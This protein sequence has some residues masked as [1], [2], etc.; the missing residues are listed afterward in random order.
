MPQAATLPA[1][2]DDQDQLDQSFQERFDKALDAA[3]PDESPDERID[4]N[5]KPKGKG[6]S[7]AAKAAPASKAPAAPPPKQ[8]RAPRA[9]APAAPQE[10]PLSDA[11]D[12]VPP[13]EPVTEPVLD[14]TEDGDV[15][16][17]AEFF[18]LTPEDLQAEYGSK[19]DFI[20]AVRLWDRRL[21]SAGGQAHEQLPPQRQPTPPPQQRPAPS[22][23]QSEQ[24]QAEADA[25]EELLKAEFLD[26]DATKKGFGAVKQRLQ[27]QEQVI[28]QLTQMLV[29]QR[30]QELS[31]KFDSLVDD[32]EIEDLGKVD[33]RGKLKQEF[34]D[35]RTEVWQLVHQMRMHAAQQ[36]GRMPPLTKSI[37]ERA[38]HIAF[39]KIQ[40]QKLRESLE[41]QS[42]RRLGTAVSSRG[43]LPAPSDRDAQDAEDLRVI[44]EKWRAMQRENGNL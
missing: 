32:L 4:P 29:G 41:S 28:S 40:T 12:Q 44:T 9:D 27:Q 42:R 8:E 21:A 33:Q 26:D 13:E 24:T 2:G 14:W 10:Q 7:K 23:P 34:A 1:T 31:D 5:G 22:Q 35:K 18:G 25:L 39:P 43:N 30:Q 3:L 16:D 38:V 6:S 36:T 11:E 20:R 15:L 17:A 37:V 19:E